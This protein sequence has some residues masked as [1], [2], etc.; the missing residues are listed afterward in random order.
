MKITQINT[1]KSS[2]NART[3]QDSLSL[4]VENQYIHLDTK[5]NL[6]MEK[7]ENKLEQLEKLEGL[8]KDLM[9]QKINLL[10]KEKIVSNQENLLKKLCDEIIN[11]PQELNAAILPRKRLKR[12]L[13][14][15][16]LFFKELKIQSHKNKEQLK[17]FYQ[18]VISLLEKNY[19]Q[20]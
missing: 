19:S 18:E 5:I 8:Y 1:I 20:K 15:V 13:E 10:H 16:C 12:D 17:Q 9:N 11:F 7:W 2:A 14:Q 3:E 4:T 6:E